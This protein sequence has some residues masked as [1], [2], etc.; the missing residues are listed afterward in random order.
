MYQHR[1]VG[2]GV[3][4]YNS[5]MYL[6]PHAITPHG[7]HVPRCDVSDDVVGGDDVLPPYGSA[8]AGVKKEGILRRRRVY[9]SPPESPRIDPVRGE[10][11]GGGGNMFPIRLPPIG[12]PGCCRLHAGTVLANPPRPESAGT[13]HVLPEFVVHARR[14]AER[15]H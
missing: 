11:S 1:N 4:A 7:E 5:D 13:E 6:A 12:H 9:W 14:L 15:L 8:I 10:Y 2:L 3:H